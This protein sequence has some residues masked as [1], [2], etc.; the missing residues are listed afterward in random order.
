MTISLAPFSGIDQ[1]PTF[2]DGLEMRNGKQT[3][4]GHTNQSKPL[5]PPIR[6][7]ETYPLEY[8]KA[9]WFPSKAA[10]LAARRRGL[11]DYVYYVGRKGYIEGCDLQKGLKEQ[12]T[13]RPY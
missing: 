12:G 13:K 7:D 10:W 3:S 6:G 1:S 8:V 11:A 9:Y 5:P 2:E 4:D